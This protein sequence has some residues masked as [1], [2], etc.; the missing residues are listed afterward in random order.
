[1]PPGMAVPGLMAAPSAAGGRVIELKH[2]RPIVPRTAGD[3]AMAAL[4][5]RPK[6]DFTIL[7][8]PDVPVRTIPAGTDIVVEGSAGGEMFVLRKGKAEVRVNGEAVEEIGPGGIFGEMALIDRSPRGAT[9]TAVEECE[10]IP[11]DERLFVVLV[12]R[13]PYFGLEV[14]RV[15]VGRLRAMDQGL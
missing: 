9:V 10:A 6:F 2:R 5:S 11:I 13:A 15:L 4:A 3:D 8:R 7:D 14:M 12:R 1:M